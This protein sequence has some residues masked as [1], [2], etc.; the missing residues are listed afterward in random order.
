MS[1]R[2]RQS[3]DSPLIA[4]TSLPRY[5]SAVPEKQT[6]LPHRREFPPTRWTLVQQVKAGGDTASRAIEELCRRYWFP[7]YAFL[8]RRGHSPHDAEDLTQGFFATLLEDESFTRATPERGRLRTFLLHA[9]EEFVIDAR[10]HATRLKRGGGAKHVPLELTDGE[11]RY[12]A[13]PL[14][15]RDPAALFHRSW[16]QTILAA[17]QTNLRTSYAAAGK[18]DLLTAIEPHLA[19]D[20]DALPYRDLA[21]RLG[22]TETALRLFVF[23]ARQKLRALLEEESRATASND[24]EADEELRWM[25]SCLTG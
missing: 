15:L 22:L 2:A 14:D 8:R 3:A 5:S 21:T 13:E 23:R 19:G 24:A 25:I 1:G 7:V 6:P 9:L 17:A 11:Q 4:A 12:A 20:D 10:R 18:T 16:A